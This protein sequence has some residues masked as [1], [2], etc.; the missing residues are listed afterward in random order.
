VVGLAEIDRKA[1]LRAMAQ[2]GGFDIVQSL[3][4]LNRGVGRT[5]LVEVRAVQDKNGATGLRR[6]L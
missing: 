3:V 2:A 4:P 5:T 6:E 1:L